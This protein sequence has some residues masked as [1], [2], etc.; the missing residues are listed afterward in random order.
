[1]RANCWPVCVC[2]K[3]LARGDGGFFLLVRAGVKG[4]Q[5]RWGVGL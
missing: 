5:G 1:M 3:R 4:C 2:G